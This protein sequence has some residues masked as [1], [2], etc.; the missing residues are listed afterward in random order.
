MKIIG[1]SE[2]G[3]ILEASRDEVANLIG[4]YFSCSDGCKMP[5]IGDELQ[6]SKMYRQL[7]DLKNRQP[8]LQKV[9]GTLRGL[10]DMLEPVC[11]VIEK[12]AKEAT[13]KT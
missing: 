2:N 9:V 11:P 13:T 8:E 6:V 10:A 7:Y 5:S 4:Y 3:F 12:A 1:K